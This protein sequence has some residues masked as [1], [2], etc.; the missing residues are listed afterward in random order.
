[1]PLECWCSCYIRPHFRRR[2]LIEVGAW[3]PY[4]VTE[5][6]DLGARF[7]RHGFRCG[8]IACPT[9]EDAP[10]AAGV[11]LGQRTRW[12]KGWMHLYPGIYKQLILREEFQKEG[13]PIAD[14]ATL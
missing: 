8:T 3:D 12:F 7:A 2:A 11:W 14:I 6:A 13:G 10:D 4:N 5:D 9:L 1:M